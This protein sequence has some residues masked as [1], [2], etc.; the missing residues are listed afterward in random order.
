ME[1]VWSVSRHPMTRVAYGLDGLSAW[2]PQHEGR[3]L[4]LLA[5][6]AV[7]GGEA[8]VRVRERAVWAGW[9]PEDVVLTGPG[10]LGSV[11]ELAE[12]LAGSDLVVAVGGGSLLDQ[13]KLAVLLRSDPNVRERLAVRHRSGLV[14]LSAGSVP[15]LP[16]VSVPTTVGTG[17]ELSG[18]VCL[19]T[20]TGKRLVLGNGLQPEVAV[21]DPA[22]TRTLPPELLAEGVLEVFFRLSGMYAGDHRELPVEDAFARTLLGLLVSF[23]DRVAAAREA[24]TV[25]G[26]GLR[27]EIAKLSGLSHQQWLNLGREPA[28]CK[29]WYLANEL[30]T[31][32][33]VRKMTAAAALLPPLWRR[34]ADGDTRWG[35]ASRL[36][37]LWRA[38][39]DERSVPTPEDPVAGITALLDDWNIDRTLHATAERTAEVARATLRAWGDG[40]PPLGALAL[41][42]VRAAMADAVRAPVPL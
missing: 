25:P 20:P 9:D 6:S 17:S 35:S 36:A 3:R 31:A 41:P 11:Q 30:S 16:L 18:A 14:L 33:G 34:I 1:T 42:D 15:R 38:V 7:A 4:V 24:G 21:Y 2:L 22:A 26:D 27:L 39:A 10:D 32:L 5:D 8:V 12:R 19:A 28:A 23:G 13:A 29:G 37:R 40:L